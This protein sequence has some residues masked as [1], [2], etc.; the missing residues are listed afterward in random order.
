MPD[1][2][3]DVV[4]VSQWRGLV[5]NAD[6][7]DIPSGAAQELSNM[8]VRAPG[9]LEVRKGNRPVTF[10][11]AIAATSNTIIAMVSYHGQLGDH[12]VYEDSAGNVKIGRAAT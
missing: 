3:K 2:P 1:Q 5:S 8:I 12:V 7:H 9:T 4:H 10:G 11:N 6:A